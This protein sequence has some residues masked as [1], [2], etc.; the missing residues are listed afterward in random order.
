[1]NL[2]AVSSLLL[3]MIK[4]FGL[5]VGRWGLWCD[6]KFLKQLSVEESREEGKKKNREKNREQTMYL[7]GYSPGAEMCTGQWMQKAWKFLINSSLIKCS[8]DQVSS[9]SAFCAGISR[10]TSPSIEVELA[11]R[12]A[13]GEVL[14]CAQGHSD[15]MCQTQGSFCSI[16]WLLQIFSCYQEN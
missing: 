8:E 2:S 12:T 4:W 15:L 9:C 11:F 14:L 10:F 7:W 16:S 3:L 1:M 6:F 13:T 5:Q